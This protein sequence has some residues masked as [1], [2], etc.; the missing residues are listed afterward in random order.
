MDFWFPVEELREGAANILVPELKNVD[1]SLKDQD[2]MKAAV[3]YNPLMQLNRDTAV[4]V[5]S[6][7]RDELMRPTEVCEPM[8]GSGV[9]GVRFALETG[10]GSVALSDLNPSGVEL[11]EENIRRNGVGNIV[12][13]RVMDAN[14]LLNI[15]SSPNYRFDYVDIDPFGTPSP[16]LDSAIRATRDG[17]ILALTATDMAPLCGVNPAACLRKYGGKPIRCTYSHEVAL[18]LLVGSAVRAAA[19]HEL[20]A[21]PVFSYY[22]DHYVRAYLKIYYSAKNADAAIANMGYIVHCEKCLYRESLKGPYLKMGRS[23]PECGTGMKVAGPMWLGELANQVMCTKML[24]KAKEMNTSWERRLE[25]IIKSVRAEIGYPPTFIQID[26]ISS[27]LHIGSQNLKA[28]L[29]KL[30]A[31]GYRA[32]T[33]HFSPRGIKTDATVIQLANVLKD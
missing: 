32:T 16:F 13:T 30:E 14:L 19:I 6:I 24:E 3:F 21:V 15:H 28:L 20:A 26:E 9:R 29:S 18:R 5:L 2:R 17:G 27:H 33:T 7:L 8:C 23:C 25:S 4:L 10:A 22:A 31:V 11:T 1:R 12:R